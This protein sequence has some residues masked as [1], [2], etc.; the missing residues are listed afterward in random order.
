[1]EK[2]FT[3]LRVGSAGNQEI[4]VSEGWWEDEKCSL[5]PCVS[6]PDSARIQWLLVISKLMFHLNGNS[7]SECE[8]S[9]NHNLGRVFRLKWRFGSKSL[10]CWFGW[11][12]NPEIMKRHR[13]L[14]VQ[15]WQDTCGKNECALQGPF[16][17]RNLELPVMLSGPTFRSL[18][19]KNLLLCNVSVIFLFCSK[20][21]LKFS[22]SLT[23]Y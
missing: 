5:P 8:E 12:S 2:I 11:M 15:C 6:L 1:M 9:S 10:D 4:A 17:H 3:L 21:T 23:F 13:T 16:T 7:E 14:V 20:A 18:H 19:K 22:F